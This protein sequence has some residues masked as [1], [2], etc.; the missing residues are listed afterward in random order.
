MER[1]LLLSKIH[2]KLSK[3]PKA[4]METSKAANWADMTPDERGARSSP[5]RAMM[6]QWFTK[7]RVT[8]AYCVDRL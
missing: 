8:D 4:A 1:M 6:W 2:S 5:T 7:T 3:F